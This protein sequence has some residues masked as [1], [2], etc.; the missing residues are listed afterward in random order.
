MPYKLLERINELCNSLTQNI[1]TSKNN[2]A[3]SEE[4]KKKLGLLIADAITTHQLLVKN[5]NREVPVLSSDTC[6]KKYNFSEMEIAELTKYVKHYNSG[7][8][9]ILSDVPKTSF[10]KKKVINKGKTETMLSF[11]EG[12]VKDLEKSIGRIGLESN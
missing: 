3:E 2:K 11:V 10:D 1:K 6:F 12:Y 7:I 5:I 9:E 8:I 4:K